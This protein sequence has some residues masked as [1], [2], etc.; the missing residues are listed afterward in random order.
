MVV[1]R[2]FPA[3]YLS[4][5]WL[6]RLVMG[7]LAGWLLFNQVGAEEFDEYAVKAA[8]LYN[9]TKY[10]EWPPEAFASP[11]APLLICIAGDNPFGKALTS[12]VGKRVDNRPVEVRLLPTATGIEH[13][14]V[15]YLGQVDQGRFK[16]WLA[17]LGPLPILTVGD[18]GDF[19]LAGGMIG[20]VKTNQRIR[21][22]INLAAT[23]LAGLRLS[24][25]LLKLATILDQGGKES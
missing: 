12:L 2:R 19:A 5:R 6:M 25:Q 18:S 13:C 21:F 24:S 9:F 8:Y 3:Q 1:L 17:K 23:R 16:A 11:E 14:H 7:A 15:L 20:L 10:V 22:T 4:R